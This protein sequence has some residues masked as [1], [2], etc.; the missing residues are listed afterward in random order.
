MLPSIGAYQSEVVFCITTPKSRQRI[1]LLAQGLL[2]SGRQV[3][4]FQVVMIREDCADWLM[5]N[6]GLHITTPAFSA[7]GLACIIYISPLVNDFHR[8]SVG[9]LGHMFG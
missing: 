3:F 4:M 7:D 1:H 8:I 2:T 5:Y 9:E 6:I